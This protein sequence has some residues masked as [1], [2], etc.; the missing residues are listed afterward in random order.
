MPLKRTRSAA[1]QRSNGNSSNVTDYFGPPEKKRQTRKAKPANNTSTRA[2]RS[3][4][5]ASVL[6][7]EPQSKA[8]S[9]RH[10]TRQQD[11]DEDDDDGSIHVAFNQVSSAVNEARFGQPPAINGLRPEVLRVRLDGVAEDED[12]IQHEEVHEEEEALQIRKRGR[13]AKKKQTQ[14]QEPPKNQQNGLSSRS[15][16][17]ATGSTDDVHDEPSSRQELRPR[18]KESSAHRTSSGKSAPMQTRQQ[19][20]KAKTSVTP[21]EDDE[22]DEDSSPEDEEG[23]EDMRG[24]EMQGNE[25]SAFI[26]PPRPD[27]KL[28]EVKCAVNNL[29][30]IIQT[31]SHPAWTGIKDWDDSPDMACSTKT[32]GELIERLR[33][34]NDLLLESYE[35]RYEGDADGDPEV[36]IGYLRR[37]NGKVKGL[38][39]GIT[40][41]VDVICTR[42]LAAV[43]KLG[44]R[45]VQTKKRFL[46]DISQRLMPMLVLV[47]QKAYDVGP[48]EEKGRTVHLTLN[49]FTI[50]F[51]LRT[52]GWASRLMDGLSRGLLKWPIDDEFDHSDVELDIADVAKRQAKK[53]KRERFQKHLASLYAIIKKAANA[54]ERNAKETERKKRQEQDRQRALVE[55]EQYRRQTMNRERELK[56]KLETQREE[57]ERKA[58]MQMEKFLQASQVLKSKQE[59]PTVLWKEAGLPRHTPAALQVHMSSSHAPLQQ[60]STGTK[61]A[62]A[63]VEDDMDFFLRNNGGSSGHPSQSANVSSAHRPQHGVPRTINGLETAQAIEAWGAP[64]WSRAEEK[65]LVLKIKFDN[66]YNASTLAPRLGRSVED[67]AKK[68]AELKA[69]YRAIYERRGDNIPAWAW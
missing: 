43:D 12:E 35:A 29:R 56:A 31:L 36:T 40:G 62:A 49:S 66:T 38:F 26:D 45:G 53:D 59:P 58:K 23:E 34:L 4:K 60:P 50:Q 44:T 21:G 33:Q 3:G 19:Q 20:Q 46:G 57:A 54:L 1:V 41:L 7:E 64:R 65:R 2:T 42:K 55:Q 10:N 63:Q 68:A 25:D 11:A 27:E 52:I 16:V 69:M 37:N 51:P 39:T 24:T 8:A 18:N 48:S 61:R 17:Q 13:S 30:G 9:T 67:V 47:L 14:Q 6:V 15:R 22:Q 32:A 5:S 28:P